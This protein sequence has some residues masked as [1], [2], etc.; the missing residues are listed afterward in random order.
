MQD[1]NQSTSF[2]LPGQ[3]SQMSLSGAAADS[4]YHSYQQQQSFAQQPLKPSINGE[5]KS[6][7]LKSTATD[8]LQSVKRSA[9]FVGDAAVLNDLLFVFQG[10]NGEFIQWNPHKQAYVIDQ[11]VCVF[12]LVKNSR[13]KERGA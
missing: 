12:F 8:P 9:P 11:K 2:L 13:L 7:G 4:A 10:T 5:K 1:G 6:A 3:L